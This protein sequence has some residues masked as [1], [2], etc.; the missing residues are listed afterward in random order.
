MCNGIHVTDG[1]IESC[2]ILRYF[3]TYVR[4]GN[5]LGKPYWI[6]YRTFYHVFNCLNWLI[7]VAC[8]FNTLFFIFTT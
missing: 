6:Y 8:L 7:S 4:P 2:R 3:E 1:L 5:I